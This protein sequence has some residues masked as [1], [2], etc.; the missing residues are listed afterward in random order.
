MIN[1]LKEINRKMA[2]HNDAMIEQQEFIIALLT[3]IRDNL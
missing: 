3:Q 2:E 1:E